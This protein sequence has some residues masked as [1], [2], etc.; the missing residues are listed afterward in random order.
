MGRRLSG[1][2]AARNTFYILAIIWGIL[3]PFFLIS[4]MI[5]PAVMQ[6]QTPGIFLIVPALVDNIM[7]GILNGGM[8]DTTRSVMMGIFMATFYILF[9]IPVS[10]VFSG[11]RCW[12]ERRYDSVIASNAGMVVGIVAFNPFL[13]IA[14]FINH[15]VYIA[16]NKYMPS[17]KGRLK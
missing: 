16:N 11:I 6:E 10:G 3:T 8:D 4:S 17:K 7:Y 2:K 9:I 5:I 12:K 15:R 14:G 13:I 1:G